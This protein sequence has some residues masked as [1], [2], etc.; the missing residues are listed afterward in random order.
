M[1]DTRSPLE[2]LIDKAT[3]F[4]PSQY[5]KLVCPT[6]KQERITKKFPFEPSNAAVLELNCPVCWVDGSEEL[7]VY[8][9]A[10]GVKIE[11]L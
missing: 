9:D 10:E 7:G 8:Y 3:G 11:E 1:K 6:C 2:K 5:L 4:N